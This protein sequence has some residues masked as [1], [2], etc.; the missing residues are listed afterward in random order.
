MPRPRKSTAEQIEDYFAEMPVDAQ[1]VMLQVLT[2]I[3]RQATR[4]V[5]EQPKLLTSLEQVQS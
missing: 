2:A 3:H 5:A 1:A 4:K